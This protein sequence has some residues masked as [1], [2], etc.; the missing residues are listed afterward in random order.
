MR[1]LGCRVFGVGLCNYSVV[2]TCRVLG[3]VLEYCAY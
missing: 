3:K 1:V 2:H